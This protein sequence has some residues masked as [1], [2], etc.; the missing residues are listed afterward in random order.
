[1]GAI[2]RALDN[3]AGVPHSPPSTHVTHQAA[4]SNVSYDY[5][6]H[7]TNNAGEAL[8]NLGHPLII[9]AG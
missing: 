7:F 3:N 4:L 2:R 5:Y 1:M 6:P 9:T 8:G